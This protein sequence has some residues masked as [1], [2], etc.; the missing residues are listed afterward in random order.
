[1][2]TVE[3]A[4]RVIKSV[5]IIMRTTPNQDLLIS[6]LMNCEGIAEIVEVYKAVTGHK[7]Y[8]GEVEEISKEAVAYDV[9]WEIMKATNPRISQ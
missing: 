5:N 6:I 1:M 2:I 4:T 8:W 9:A 7:Y 3:Q